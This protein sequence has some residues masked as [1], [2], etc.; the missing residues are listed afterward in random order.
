MTC[1]GH[2]PCA[3][4][5]RETAYAC[6]VCPKGR[7]AGSPLPLGRLP[8][9]VLQLERAMPAELPAG[10]R[11]AG[12][13]EDPWEESSSRGLREDGVKL[14]PKNAQFLRTFPHTAFLFSAFSPIF[15]RR[16]VSPRRP[17]P[18]TSWVTVVVE[19]RHGLAGIPHCQCYCM[20][21]PAGDGGGKR[22]A[23]AAEPKPWERGAALFTGRKKRGP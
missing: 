11:Q 4:K 19:N 7:A 18:A 9:L 14:A 5:K 6:P 16:L 15:C 10:L 12:V 21:A 20:R 13:Y 17:H 3:P 1:N 22:V 23:G 2:I 8:L